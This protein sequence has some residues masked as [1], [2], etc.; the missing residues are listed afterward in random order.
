MNAAAPPRLFVLLRGGAVV[1][2]QALVLGTLRVSVRVVV[3]V[4]AFEVV[5]AVALTA[6]L[7]RRARVAAPLASLIETGALAPALSVPFWVP[8]SATTFT[9]WSR[10]GLAVVRDSVALQPGAVPV[11]Q[12]T[13]M[14]ATSEPLRR[15]S[16]ALPILRAWTLSAAAGSSDS[17][18]STMSTPGA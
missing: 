8:S 12:D 11:G 5:T 18:P 14:R 10:S 6:S 9:P 2:R 4:P 17:T 15:T 7:R 13:A 16:L 3:A 1:A